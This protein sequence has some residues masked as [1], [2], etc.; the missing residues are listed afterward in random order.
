MGIDNVSE[1]P[2]TVRDENGAQSTAAGAENHE[3]KQTN[4]IKQ[5]ENVPVFLKSGDVSTADEEDAAQIGEF[6]SNRK[7]RKQRRA[8]LKE[9]L[10]E[11]TDESGNKIYSHKQAKKLAKYQ[12][13]N[14][15]DQA[16]AKITVPF[17][18]EEAYE[19]FKAALKAEGKEDLYK[20]T[21]IKNKKVLAMIN[22]DNITD[23]AEKIE[24]AKKWFMTDGNGELIIGDNGQY[25]FDPEKY[26]AEM[27]K[28][29]SDTGY[30]LTLAGRAQ[31]AKERG[32]SKNAEKDA[33]KAAGLGY[34]KDRTWL[35][36]TLLCTAGAAAF[37]FGGATAT[38]ASAAAAGA[39]A[40]A[41]N[42]SAEASSTSASKATASNRVGQIL[43]G[44]ACLIA[45]A[46][47]KDRD[48]GKD[49]R[50]EAQGVFETG[51]EQP[52]QEEQ[53]AVE[54]QEEI[55]EEEL[56]PEEE[57]AELPCMQPKEVLPETTRISTIR[58]GGPYHYAQLYV[59]E[60]GSPLK[61]GSAEF[62]ELQRKLSSG[63]YSIQVIDR[64]TRELVNEIPLKS[65][66]ARLAAD[67]DAKAKK[68]FDDA[69]IVDGSGDRKYAK[70]QRNG[71][72]VVVYCDTGELVPN[73]KE[74]N[75]FDE[76]QDEIDQMSK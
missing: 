46:L 25:V 17:I 50:A 55:Q 72:W 47:I 3:G 21:L 61:K 22:G 16:K 20:P 75:S 33:V 74:H 19:N 57:C 67:A 24:N 34:R 2:I 32:L 5:Q 63:K 73:T 12:V 64:K 51:T 76:A 53:G 28:D 27:S 45:A 15:K 69:K 29:A 30:R 9:Y 23:Q 31:H 66:T 8:E 35:Y 68:G 11:Q 58:G 71:K 13:R 56:P 52:V 37:V 7:A 1:T 40:T 59:D 10:L 62:R 41:G 65:G 44:T 4:P 49:R 26:K 36:K 42:V 54:P 14:E 43:G 38:A 18:D 70:V 48:F 60:N 39:G 6:L